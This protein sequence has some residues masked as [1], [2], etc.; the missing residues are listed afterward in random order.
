MTDV[1][2]TASNRIERIMFILGRTSKPD[3]DDIAE[4]SI[5]F[6]ASDEDL[7]RATC[8]RDGSV[9]TLIGT[10]CFTCPAD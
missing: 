1:S 3:F 8:A 9:P 2:T 5:F 7:E 6:D 4:E 10:Y